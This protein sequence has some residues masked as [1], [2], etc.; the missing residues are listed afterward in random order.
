MQQFEILKF[1]EFSTLSLRT[2]ISVTP[3][4]GL[5]IEQFQNK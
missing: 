1:V 5:L 3:N 4:L 2:L